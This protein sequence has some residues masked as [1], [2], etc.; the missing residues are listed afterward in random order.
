MIYRDKEITVDD[1][2]RIMKET[3]VKVASGTVRS[4]ETARDLLVKAARYQIAKEPLDQQRVHGNGYLE[5]ACPT[6]KNMVDEIEDTNYCHECGQ[7]L[8]W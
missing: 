4:Y 5:G 8:S 3:R 1:A 6:C 7:K 2:I